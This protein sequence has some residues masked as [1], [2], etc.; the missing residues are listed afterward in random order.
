MRA[1]KYKQAYGS[2]MLIRSIVHWL[3]KVLKAK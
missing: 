2:G 3:R 1:S